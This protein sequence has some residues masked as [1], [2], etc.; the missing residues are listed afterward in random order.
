MSGLVPLHPVDM[1]VA[2]RLAEAPEEKYADLGASL[3][4]SM[5]TAHAAVARLERSGLLRPASRTVNWLALREFLAHGLRY[6]FPARPGAAV[7]GVPTA[8]A[9]PPL[10]QHFSSDEAYVWPDARGP[11]M[12]RAITPLY[13]QAIGL[14]TR[15]PS[16]YHL[17]ALA[18]ALRAGRARE[19]KLALDTLG[20]LLGPSAGRA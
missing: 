18:D 17:L 11:V 13:P 10:A 1:P 14:P 2:L 4:I 5:S 20:A 6:A 15:C 12:G 9:A 7:A 8:H 19:R 16:L 3:G